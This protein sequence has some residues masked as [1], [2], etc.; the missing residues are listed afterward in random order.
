MDNNY[1]QQFAQSLNVTPAPV[2]NNDNSKLPLIIVAILVVIT[3]IESIALVISLANQSNLATAEG[4]E[5]N[6]ENVDYTEYGATEYKFDDNDN[7]IAFKL[8]C[9][10]ENGASFRLTTDQKYQQ[11][12]AS[13]Q[14]AESGTY[15]IISDSIISLSGPNDSKRTIFYDGLI[16]ADGNTIYDCYITNSSEG[17]EGAGV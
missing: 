1:E 13:G 7:I 10:N 16:L 2:K 15:T 8:D 14:A 12:D 6:T 5:E 3:L 17:T 11:S 4:A 9:K